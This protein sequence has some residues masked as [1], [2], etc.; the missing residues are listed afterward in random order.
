M[1]GEPNLHEP[2]FRCSPCTDKDGIRETNC[3][4]PAGYQGRIDLEEKWEA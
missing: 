3:G 1:A 4:N 2:E